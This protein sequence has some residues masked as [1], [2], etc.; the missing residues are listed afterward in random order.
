MSL[1]KTLAGFAV[2]LVAMLGGIGFAQA[3]ANAIPPASQPASS[4]DTGGGDHG[5]WP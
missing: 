4:V 5:I 2:A 3:D 1:K